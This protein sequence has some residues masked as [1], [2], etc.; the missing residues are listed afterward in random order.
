MWFA[1]FS[2]S[3]MTA[4]KHGAYALAHYA[5]SHRDEVG[6]AL[7]QGLEKPHCIM[8]IQCMSD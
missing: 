5:L 2:M 6:E 3:G 4:F 1:H 8:R 7:V